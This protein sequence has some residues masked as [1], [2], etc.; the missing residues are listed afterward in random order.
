MGFEKEARREY[1]RNQGKELGKT[2]GPLDI[3]SDTVC[4][5]FYI[6]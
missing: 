2:L 3:F 1:A 4:G 6:L 5:F